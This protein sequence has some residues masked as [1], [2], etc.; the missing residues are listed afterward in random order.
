MAFFVIMINNTCDLG[1]LLKHLCFVIIYTC[2]NKCK[3]CFSRKRFKKA[4][5]IYM[6]I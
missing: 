5:T 2:P 3:F 4:T 6:K 1:A